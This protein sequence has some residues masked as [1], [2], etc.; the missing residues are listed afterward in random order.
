MQ[1]A[2]DK[3]VLLLLGSLSDYRV[4]IYNLINKKYEIL[5]KKGEVLVEGDVTYLKLPIEKI[6]K[7]VDVAHELPYLIEDD[8]KEIEDEK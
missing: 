6:N 4:P 3:K 2:D 7:N 8:I 1:I 5:N